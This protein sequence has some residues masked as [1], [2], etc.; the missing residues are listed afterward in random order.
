METTFCMI[1]PDSADKKNVGAIL[2][3]LEKKN[4]TIRQAKWLHLSASFC[5]IFYHEHKDK[6]FFP[7]LVEFIS[8]GP[9]LALALERKDACLYLR[10]VM[11]ATN[12][13]EAAETTIRFLFGESVERNAL[14]GS[15]SLVSARRE[16]SLFFPEESF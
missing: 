12:P 14:H 11:G 2:S 16:L 10:E 8:S 15:D 7:S 4:F 5:E 9:V 3:F 6:E 1:K 13:K